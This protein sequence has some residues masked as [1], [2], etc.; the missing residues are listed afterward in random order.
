MSI[1]WL[2]TGNELTPD[3]ISNEGILP[4]LVK[5]DTELKTKLNGKNSETANIDAKVAR[6]EKTVY[7]GG[8]QQRTAVTEPVEGQGE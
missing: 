2:D 6:L 8:Q 4:A 3:E 5:L 1:R 7:G